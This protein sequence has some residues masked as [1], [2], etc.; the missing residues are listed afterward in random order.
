MA[1][2]K[3]FIG[4]HKTDGGIHTANC[5]IPERMLREVYLKPFQAAITEGNLKGVM[6]SYN[7]LN[8]E[9]VSGSEYLLTKVLREEM[10]FDGIV[11]SDYTSISEMHVRQKMYESNEIAGLAALKAGVDQELPSKMCYGDTLKQWF[12][13]KTI[14]IELLDR[15]VKRILRIKFELGLFENPF[16]QSETEIVRV[17]TEQKHKEIALESAKKSLILLKNDGTLPISKDIKKIAVIGYHAGTIRAMFGGYTAMSLFE[18]DLVGDNTMA[19]VNK[20]EITYEALAKLIGERSSRPKHNGSVVQK[21]DSDIDERV[22][23]RYPGMLSLFE[24]LK[25]AREKIC[26]TYAS[27]YSYT[28]DD[29]SGHEEALKIA[30]DADLV[31]VTLGGKYGTGSTASTGEG[32]DATNINLPKCQEVFLEKLN[33]LN[34]V[35]VAIHFDGRPISSDSAQRCA[36]AIIEAWNPSE[37]GPEAIV[38]VLFGEYNPAGRLPVSIAYHSGQLPVHYNHL[39]GSS[40]SQNT[41]GYFKNYIDCPHEPRYYFGHGL[42]YT[43]FAYENLNLSS[44]AIYPKDCLY[45]EV[46]IKNIGDYDGEEVAQLYIEDKYASMI[47][48]N[49][50]LVGFKR[51][52]LQRGEKKRVKFKVD[53]SQLAFVDSSMQW[54]IEKGEMIV[55]M[56]ASSSDIRL[57]D[58]FQISESIYVDGK[59]RSFYSIGEVADAAIK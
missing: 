46:D 55:Q 14:D 28:G 18:S 36:N 56:G 5:D 6:T 52:F 22:V 13:N 10:G 1:T 31:I 2:T 37:K 35:T 49:K 54:K 53:L 58:V 29:L 41:L 59:T 42:S 19:G 38:S 3:H 47:R 17:Y 30:K 45:I 33:Q 15:T 39:K 21:E 51:I 12:D 48:P 4:Y 27:G 44:K 32:I 43:T 57:T 25:K 7:T 9:S 16:A 24:Q 23:S 20:Q 50:E 11:V 8:G 26:F 40:Y 34:K